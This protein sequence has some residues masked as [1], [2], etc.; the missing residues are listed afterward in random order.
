MTCRENLAS[1]D[2]WADSC[3]LWQQ[4][5]FAFLIWNCIVPACVSQIGGL[6]P[7]TISKVEE[8]CEAG[9]AA[10]QGWQVRSS[11]EYI[12][13]GIRIETAVCRLSGGNLQYPCWSSTR[14]PW[15]SNCQPPWRKAPT[16]IEISEAPGKAAKD[17]YKAAHWK[18]SEST[19]IAAAR[20]FQWLPQPTAD[21]PSTESDKS[22]AVLSSHYDATWMFL[23]F[24][25]SIFLAC[26]QPSIAAPKV[27][28]EVLFIERRRW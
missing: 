12:Q 16:T 17:S 5:A 4:S 7:S 18:Q 28:M 13:K 22:E 23:L 9:A 15:P 24:D 14:E 1:S 19:S 27:E 6:G 3:E 11:E 21:S 2:L 26:E 8:M 25:K 20:D 10:P